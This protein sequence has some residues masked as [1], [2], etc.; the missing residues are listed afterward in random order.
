MVGKRGPLAFE[1]PLPRG[2]QVGHQS[3]YV[4]VD[5]GMHVRIYDPGPRSISHVRLHL[6]RS[7]LSSLNASRVYRASSNNR[8]RVRA[9]RLATFRILPILRAIKAAPNR[10]LTHSLPAYLRSLLFTVLIAPRR[11]LPTQ[12]QICTYNRNGVRNR[13]QRASSSAPEIGLLKPSG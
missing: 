10:P 13:C 5:P 9:D 1:T 3:L 7:K 4:A 8:L 11:V 12:S 2:T 6:R